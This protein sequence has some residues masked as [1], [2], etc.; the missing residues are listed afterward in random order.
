[1]LLEGVLILCST[2]G[3]RN[4]YFGDSPGFRDAVTRHHCVDNHPVLLLSSVHRRRGRRCGRLTP[5]GS[6]RFESTAGTKLPINHRFS[7]INCIYIYPFF[8]NLANE[9]IIPKM[10]WITCSFP[11]HV[12][13][14]WVKVG[15]RMI[16]E[17]GGYPS[18]YCHR[19][20]SMIN[21]VF[22]RGLLGEATYIYIYKRRI[23]G[24]EGLFFRHNASRRSMV[25]SFAL[26]ATIYHTRVAIKS[27]KH[28]RRGTKLNCK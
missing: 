19:V 24:E 17:Q 16:F 1:M 27:F 9:P 21:A 5:R 4:K 23:P 20:S 2:G 8:P 7:T 22:I 3:G 12:S 14:S 18:R 26:K 10:R 28:S 6:C 15:D 13:N 11:R 25:T